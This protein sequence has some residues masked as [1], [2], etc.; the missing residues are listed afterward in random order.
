MTHNHQS[1]QLIVHIKNNLLLVKDYILLVKIKKHIAT[2]NWWDQWIVHY[3]ISQSTIFITPWGNF[4]T[5]MC[6]IIRIALDKKS[7]KKGKFYSYLSPISGL[8]P[9]LRTL[10]LGNGSNLCTKNRKLLTSAGIFFWTNS[11]MPKVEPSSK[12][13]FGSSSGAT[14]QGVHNYPISFGTRRTYSNNEESRF[15]PVCPFSADPQ[16]S[17]QLR[18]IFKKPA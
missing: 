15:Q 1:H 2:V 8:V 4:L 12:E 6:K 9:C 13:V 7:S 5:R 18:N 14:L 17:N 3:N 16:G 11:N 10:M